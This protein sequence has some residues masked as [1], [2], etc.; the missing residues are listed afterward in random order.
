[1]DLVSNDAFKPANPTYKLLVT[2][3]QEYDSAALT[4]LKEDIIKKIQNKHFLCEII[5]FLLNQMSEENNPASI[6]L[7]QDDLLKCLNALPEKTYNFKAINME[8]IKK[9]FA[10]GALDKAKIQACLILL[11]SQCPF[12][13]QLNT[14]SFIKD[15]LALIR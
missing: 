7:A 10:E 4:N 5:P 13:E 2:L 11:A 1:S 8:L 9:I 15:E 14:S 12:Y 6:Q 3:D